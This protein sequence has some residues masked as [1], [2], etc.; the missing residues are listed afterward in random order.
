[1]VSTTKTDTVKSVTAIEVNFLIDMKRRH[2]FDNYNRYREV[3]DTKTD[4][5]KSVTAIEVYV[6]IDK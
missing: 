5:V 3:G 6:L 1:M 4:T 2:G